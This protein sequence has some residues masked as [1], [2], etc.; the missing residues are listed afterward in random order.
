M[1]DR[2]SIPRALG[3]ALVEAAALANAEQALAAAAARTQKLQS[4][5]SR[6]VDNEMREI[7]QAA[8]E[9]DAL[10]EERQ[11]ASQKLREE[12]ET[13]SD[14]GASLPYDPAG[15]ERLEQLAGAIRGSFVTIEAARRRIEELGDRAERIIAALNKP[16]V[17]NH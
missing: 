17:P 1:A 15:I 3:N 7:E 13:F 9:A 8:A 11:K 4:E 10:N 14:R 2:L 16:A 6:R 5:L 12:I